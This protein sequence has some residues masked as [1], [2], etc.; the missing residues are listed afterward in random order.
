MLY[1]TFDRFVAPAIIDE[2]HDQRLIHTPNT[3]NLPAYWKFLQNYTGEPIILSK[4]STLVS[5]DSVF[6]LSCHADGT[7]ITPFEI[8]LRERHDIHDYL[9]P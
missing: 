6:V 8:S 1:S 3:P 9:E 7:A 5:E 2:F 4:A